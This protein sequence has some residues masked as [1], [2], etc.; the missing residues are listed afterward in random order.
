MTQGILATV[1]LGILF[2][3][4]ATESIG[5]HSIFGAFVLGAIIP[6]RS[7]LARRANGEAGRFRNCFP[8]AGF[9]C[10]HRAA[11][12][13]RAGQRCPRLGVLSADHRGRVRR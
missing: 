13:D 7:K 2:S 3:S 1:L 10:I 6:N 11:Y 4:L 9:L 5:I 12:A 8:P